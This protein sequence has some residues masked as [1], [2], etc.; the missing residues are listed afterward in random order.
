MSGDIF[1]QGNGGEIETLSGA[2]VI[3]L[4]DLLRGK[5]FSELSRISLG[6]YAEYNSYFK[7][8]LAKL[9][10]DLKSLPPKSQDLEYKA[11]IKLKKMIETPS[12]RLS[13]EQRQE[14]LKIYNSAVTSIEANMSRLEIIPQKSKAVAETFDI[15]A[16]KSLETMQS[17]QRQLLLIMQRPTR[18]NLEEKIK[19][20]RSQI[21]INNDAIDNKITLAVSKRRLF[22]EYD[23]IVDILTNIKRVSSKRIELVIDNFG[24][25]VLNSSS[26]PIPYSYSEEQ[27]Q[28]LF[29]LLKTRGVVD[30]IYFSEFYNESF[31]PISRENFWDFDQVAFA[32][33]KKNEFAKSLVLMKLSPIQNVL[34]AYGHVARLTYAGY[35]TSDERT[36]AFL[37]AELSETEEDAQE[38]DS[39]GYGFVCTG[40]AQYFK[41]ILD[42]VK[43][44]GI[45]CKLVAINMYG[46]EDLKKRFEATHVAVLVHLVDERFGVRGYYL[47]DP[48]LDLSNG[49]SFSNC[50]VPLSDIDKYKRKI[51]VVEENE[52]VP[53]EDFLLRSKRVDQLEKRWNN[54]AFLSKYI[55]SL[56]IKVEQ[57]KD[58]L[59]DIFSR[60]RK[61]PKT[62]L[63]F[64]E[65]RSSDKS[66]EQLAIDA[67]NRTIGY[68]YDYSPESATNDFYKKM[69]DFY[70]MNLEDGY[71]DWIENWVTHN[72]SLMFTESDFHK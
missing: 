59:Q 41:A 54:G 48:T 21:E 9:E 61:L 46:K 42:E 62:A 50:L 32:N 2:M 11:Y 19:L 65:A 18:V 25:E 72:A 20:Y 26:T 63:G 67:I 55:D 7:E 49:I 27:M 58:A 53:L 44:K 4:E 24:Y 13:L 8:R 43:D 36:R 30:E 39:Q 64:E 68:L 60:A 5:P 17:L 14:I 15:G 29:N 70:L 40:V 45:E 33:Y 57:F 22:E 10:R 69:R 16:A 38:L 56:P 28:M 37:T 52:N 3:R 1:S 23:K 6:L 35:A 47:C 12:E 34:A 66:D 51:M 31:M 71:E